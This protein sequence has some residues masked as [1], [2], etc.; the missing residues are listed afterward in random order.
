ME[1]Q[2]SFELISL[3]FQHQINDK[4]LMQLQLVIDNLFVALYSECILQNYHTNL[5]IGDGFRYD[6]RFKVW[7]SLV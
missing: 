4:L 7:N 5:M 3:N 1:I 6:K 2:S